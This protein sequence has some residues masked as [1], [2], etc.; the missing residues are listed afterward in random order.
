MEINMSEFT[1]IVCNFLKLPAYNLA[2]D[3]SYAAKNSENE[4][5]NDFIVGGLMSFY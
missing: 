3:N 2:N 5:D 4:E 1:T